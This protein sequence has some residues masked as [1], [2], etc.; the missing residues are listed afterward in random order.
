MP[1]PCKRRRI[2]GRPPCIR[3]GPLT[4]NE[5]A[6][7]EIVMTLDEYECI[8]LIDLNGLTQEE[9]GRQ[10][11]VARAT[12]QA[13]YS[14]ARRKIA[15]CLTERMQLKISGGNYV[16]CGK[17]CRGKGCGHCRREYEEQVDEEI[18]SGGENH[19][20]RSNL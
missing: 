10:M 8:R 2:C 3:F 11:G 12:V 18:G 9:C 1:R 15:Q 14:S 13:I 16:V 5:E 17:G 6:V 20:D 19:E 4:D 7:Q